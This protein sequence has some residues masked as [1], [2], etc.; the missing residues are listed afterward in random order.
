MQWAPACLSLNPTNFCILRWVARSM[1]WSS[2]RPRVWCSK[3][4]FF[5]NF[6]QNSL[7]I[8]F[9]LILDFLYNSKVINIKSFE[10]PKPKVATL[11]FI[12]NQSK[13]YLDHQTFGQWDDHP[14]EPAYYED[15]WIFSSPPKDCFWRVN[16]I[17]TYFDLWSKRSK[18]E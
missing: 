14:S 2:H 6:W 7:Q 18:I 4:F 1:G 3:H 10:F 12:F 16:L 13:E 8:S 15:C 11:C 5:H 17:L 9:Q